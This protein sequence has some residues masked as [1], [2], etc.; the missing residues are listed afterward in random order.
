MRTI[1]DEIPCTKLQSRTDQAEVI[2]NRL[3]DGLRIS[4]GQLTSTRKRWMNRTGPASSR[5]RATNR[6][7]P[8]TQAKTKARTERRGRRTPQ[9]CLHKAPVGTRMNRCPPCSPRQADSRAYVGHP[10][11]AVGRLGIAG[12]ARPP[13]CV[14]GIDKPQ[15]RTGLRS[16]YRLTV[17]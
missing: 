14:Q 12:I 7:D 6:S 10:G 4:C 11:Q 16:I 15:A 17:Q 3:E 13:P 2:T 1:I 5:S 9:T 8:S